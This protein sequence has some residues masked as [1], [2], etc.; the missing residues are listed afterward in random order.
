MELVYVIGSKDTGVPFKIGKS[1]KK[2]LKNRLQSIQTGNP[3][4][5]EIF[6]QYHSKKINSLVLEKTIRDKLVQKY[7]FKK[8]NGEWITTDADK[9]IETVGTS[10]QSILKD[11]EYKPKDD[12]NYHALIKKRELQHKKYNNA[13]NKYNKK[14]EQFVHFMSEFLLERQKINAMDK[15]LITTS[16][17]LLTYKINETEPYDWNYKSNYNNFLEWINLFYKMYNKQ[18]RYNGMNQQSYN[19]K[20]EINNFFDKNITMYMSK[21]NDGIA[22]TKYTFNT[23]DGEI[24]AE[25][26]YRDEAMCTLRRGENR[27]IGKC[28]L[29]DTTINR[30][31]NINNDNVDLYDSINFNV[32]KEL[33]YH[34]KEI[35][36]SYNNEKSKTYILKE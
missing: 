12:P 4:S 19:H 5:L 25:T 30:R 7:G 10:I 36:I 3:N 1:N 28:Y 31:Y 2:S 11:L 20:F 32:P 9:P 13:V 24:T 34:P 33:T 18:V 8:L 23:D 17:K 26:P 14:A 27:K 16:N 6:Y 22:T 15:G 29:D 35:T 21:E